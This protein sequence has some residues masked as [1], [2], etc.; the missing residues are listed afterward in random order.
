VR[1][2]MGVTSVSQTRLYSQSS[3]VDLVRIATLPYERNSKSSETQHPFIDSDSTM[4]PVIAIE[5]LAA[6]VAKGRRAGNLATASAIAAISRP[7]EKA[8][9]P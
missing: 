9:R 8:Q 5:T 6:R 4:A 3:L 2:K 1:A 7:R